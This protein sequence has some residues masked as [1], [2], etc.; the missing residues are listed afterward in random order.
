MPDFP[1]P[2]PRGAP[3]AQAD[4][5][6]LATWPPDAIAALMNHFALLPAA[7]ASVAST[8][9]AAIQP[10]LALVAEMESLAQR[11]TAIESEVAEL[12][13]ARSEDGAQ[14][15]AANDAA[16]RKRAKQ[17]RSKG[18]VLDRILSVPKENLTAEQAAVRAELKELVKTQLK[19]LTGIQ[20]NGTLNP[21]DKDNTDGESD[22]DFPVSDDENPAAEKFLHFDF[23]QDVTAL[24]NEL[25]IQRAADIVWR[26]QMDKET[27]TLTHKNTLFT[28]KDLVS[29]GKD[30]YRE[31]RRK[32]NIASDPILAKKR[33]L[34]Q[35]INRRVQRQKALQEDREKV[36]A[37]YQTKYKRNVAAVLEEAAWMSDELSGLDTDD[38][39]KRRTHRD[40]L[41]TAARLS[42]EDRD[43][44]VPV[45][46]VRRPAYRTQEVNDIIDELDGL[47]REQRK[48]NRKAKRATTKRVNLGRLRQDPPDV[49]VY[50]FMLDTEWFKTY[51]AA[52][53]GDDLF[54]KPEDPKEFG[55]E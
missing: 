40:E 3:F 12:K 17:S 2:G 49:P 26:E 53:P 1:S 42:K 14:A 16:P 27:C 29:F 55:A 47:R 5:H 45:W 21:E 38:E 11:L 52:H 36:L 7:G 34:K 44:G 33:A 4:G 31:W 35:A 43:E 51:K 50:P 30:N 8:D 37:A 25:V 19:L 24:A 23:T 46:E 13:R 10:N 22:D 20:S 15:G 54:A 28:L 39:T 18:G 41:A 6:P 48:A 9:N 32:R